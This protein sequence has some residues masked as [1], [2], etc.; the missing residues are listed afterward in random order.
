M[1]IIEI[2]EL[3]AVTAI[4]LPVAAKLLGISPK[5]LRKWKRKAM[6]QGGYL[7]INGQTVLFD[8]QQN[9]ENGRG[10]RIYFEEDFVE[11]IKDARQVRP[12]AARKPPKR[13]LKLDGL[14]QLSTVPGL[15]PEE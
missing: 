8:C 11:T 6:E 13:K 5:T 7:S 15:P 1:S 2:L 10:A 9:Q 3:V 14:S 4:S 12:K